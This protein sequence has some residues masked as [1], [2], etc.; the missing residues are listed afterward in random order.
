MGPVVILHLPHGGGMTG[1]LPSMTGG[2]ARL[3]PKVVPPVFIPTNGVQGT[4]FSTPLTALVIF[5]LFRSR[6][7]TGCVVR[8]AEEW[9][10]MPGSCLAGDLVPGLPRRGPTGAR[11]WV[12]VR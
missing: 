9:L 4:V 6:H 3:F 5:C 2:A 11:V 10:C 8:G 7:P 12:A 1:G